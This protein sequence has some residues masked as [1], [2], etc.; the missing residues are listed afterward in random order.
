MKSIIVSITFV[1]T[2]MSFQKVNCQSLSRQKET[3][4][5]YLEE[6][7]NKQRL[8]LLDQVFADTVL[9]HILLDGSQ[10]QTPIAKQRDFLKYLFIA[11]PDI[12]YTIGDIVEENDKIAMRATLN[13]THKDEF[14]GHTA[15]GN[16]IKSIS[17]I[18][19]FRFQNGKVVE[20]WVQL[21]LYNFFKQLEDEK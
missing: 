15:K 4:R 8:D 16:K 21:D 18:F 7:V 6:V 17:E 13:A 12:H 10:S 5:F 11:F 14:W 2:C 20:N 19:F 9:V 1:M 3:A